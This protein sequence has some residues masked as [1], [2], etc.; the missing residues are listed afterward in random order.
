[1]L[2]WYIAMGD[3]QAPLESI[4]I[5][6]IRKVTDPIREHIAA[7][8]APIVSEGDLA[9]IFIVGEDRTLT[10]QLRGDALIVNRAR[11]ILGSSEK[12]GPLLS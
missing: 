11:D 9:V 3:R 4:E 12:V 2:K 8:L 5:P 10:V 6:A 1:M 7:K